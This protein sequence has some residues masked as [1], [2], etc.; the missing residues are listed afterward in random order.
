MLITF[1]TGTVYADKSINEVISHTFNLNIENTYYP[2]S[3]T[4]NPQGYVI[5]FYE[6]GTT[7]ITFNNICETGIYYICFKGFGTDL[8][9]IT[10]TFTGYDTNNFMI[11]CYENLFNVPNYNGV[12]LYNLFL[13][14]PFGEW[15]ATGENITVKNIFINSNF[16]EQF[17]INACISII[18]RAETVPLLYDDMD[19]NMKIDT[20]NYTITIIDR[21]GD[22]L[23]FFGGGDDSMS[24][25]ENLAELLYGTAENKKRP[26]KIIFY[27]CEWKDISGRSNACIGSQ[28]ME[29]AL[30]IDCDFNNLTS[31]DSFFMDFPCRKIYFSDN[32][33]NAENNRYGD[34]LF[35]TPSLTTLCN[36]TINMPN[37]YGGRCRR[38]YIFKFRN[39]A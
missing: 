1:L 3:Q 15:H 4:D 31:M 5:C 22:E 33:L 17:L 8:K 23:G 21:D 36:L 13:H 2:T 32:I 9:G 38:K 26:L 10:G 7:D 35:H 6:P 34:F 14:D 12:Y 30:F 18:K 20:D 28:S 39:C 19:A 24:R 11:E 27:N 25:E 16:D 37:W 29:S